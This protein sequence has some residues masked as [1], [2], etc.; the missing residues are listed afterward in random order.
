M[1]ADS[2]LQSISELIPHIS[3]HAPGT[4][5][6][7]AFVVALVLL[8]F[9]ALIS[10][11]EVA[12]FSLRPADIDQLRKDKSKNSDVLLKHLEQPEWLLATV[13]IANN[14]INVG[15]VMLLAFG[16]TAASDFGEMAW[17]KFLFEAVVITSVILF[18]GEIL[19]K[20]YAT[21]F[22]NKFARFMAFPIMGARKVTK[23]L[24]FILVSSTNLVNRRLSRKVKSLSM[25]QLSQALELTANELTDEKDILEGIVKFGNIYVGEIM[26]PRVDVIDLDC[27]SDYNKVLAVI[28][29]SGYSRIPVYEETPDNVKGVLYVKDLLAHLD[30][31]TGFEWQKTIRPAY[32]VPETKK[33]NDLLAEFQSKKIHLAIVVDEYGGTAG[34]VTLEDILEEIVG[35]ISDETD[36]EEVN[37]SVL[38]DG[39]YIFE[40]KTLLNDFHKVT[41]T[42]DD[43][44]EDVEGDAE[45]LAG[46]LLE[47]KGEIPKKNETIEYRDYHFTVVSADNRRIKKVKFTTKPIGNKQ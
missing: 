41:N 11:S 10:G 3:F 34:I 43:V 35:D 45:T 44:F 33:I 9:S 47:I 30:E 24:A 23:P 21:R 38:P 29:E 36:D 39:S 37:Y 5:G 13:L 18:F 1:E 12:F 15:I 32:F 16:L 20:V 27:K 4:T 14:F 46:L 19:P 42:S 8:I 26:T 17:A 40:G 25:D 7:I 2:S 22:A 31:P 6:T 28:V